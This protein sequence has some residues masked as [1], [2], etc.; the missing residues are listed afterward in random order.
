[1]EDRCAA[2]T[3]RAVAVRDLPKGKGRSVPINP[4]SEQAG[5]FGKQLASL[6]GLFRASAD[7]LE[8]VDLLAR[9]GWIIPTHMSLPELHKLVLQNSLTMERVDN[10]FVEYYRQPSR[11]ASLSKHLLSSRLTFWRPL[12]EQ[13]LKAFERGDYEICVPSLLLVLDG[14]MAS[15]WKAKVWHT[16]SRN[17]FFER[18]IHGSHSQSVVGYM[19]RSVQVFINEVFEDNVTPGRDYPI[20]KRHLILHGTSDPSKWGEAHCLRLFQA[21]STIVSLQST[22]ESRDKVRT[23]KVR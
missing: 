4:I 14:A 12:L 16:R 17:K 21:I 7:V 18:K 20:V 11:F 22:T 19:W 5:Q 13:C 23:H 15:L 8:R 2:T 10:W 1:L 6:F 3:T 9:L